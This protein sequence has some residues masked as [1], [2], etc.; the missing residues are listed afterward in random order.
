MTSNGFRYQYR[1]ALIVAYCH[2]KHVGHILYFL[3]PSSCCTTS[4][5]YWRCT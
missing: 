2:I 1:K 4:T 5:R 3:H